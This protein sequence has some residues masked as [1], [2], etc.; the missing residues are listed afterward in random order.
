[1][2]RQ[3]GFSSTS[4]AYSSGRRFSPVLSAGQATS[5]QS[6]PRLQTGIFNCPFPTDRPHSPPSS[7][8]FSITIMSIISSS[9]EFSDSLDDFFQGKKK[10]TK[11]QKEKFSARN[12]NNGRCLSMVS[13]CRYISLATCTTPSKSQT[14]QIAFSV[15]VFVLFFASD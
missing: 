11:K 7:H 14:R 5:H 6:P 15:D 13:S 3:T 12:R 8:S 10:S 4:F 2:Q 9:P 1:M